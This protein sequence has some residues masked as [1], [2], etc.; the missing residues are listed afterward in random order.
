MRYL[1][2]LAV[3]ALMVGTASAQ[4]V[5]ISPS[6]S[7]TVAGSVEMTGPVICPATTMA[8]PQ[9]CPVLVSAPLQR[10]SAILVL[11]SQERFALSYLPASDV[12]WRDY[13]FMYHSY[14]DQGN[15]ATH[16]RPSPMVTRHG[17]PFYPYHQVTAE[18]HPEA[19]AVRTV[20]LPATI[21]DTDRGTLATVSER[22]RA[23]TPSQAQVLGYAPIGACS[24]GMGQIYV[25]PALV[26]ATIDPL[27]PEAFTFGPDGRVL[28]AIHIVRSP[29][30][31]MIYGQPTT[32]SS[33]SP[34]DQQLMVW[35][36]EPNPNGFFAATNPN[37]R[38]TL[39]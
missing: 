36:F 23:M 28:S 17:N 33:I 38:C 9:P 29:T 27:R 6:S 21:S 16:Y 3:V 26:D 7:P 24:A 12:G 32:V 10:D 35:V 31:V 18:L 5:G 22:Y 11:G 4:M 15:P 20:T 34:G 8:T 37:A 39:L 14:F 2:M 1:L 25:N 13:S 19:L 30:P